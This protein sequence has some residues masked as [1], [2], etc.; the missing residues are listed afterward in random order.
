[1]KKYLSILTALIAV[2]FTSCSND[3]IPV[4][5]PTQIRVN[6][7]T[8]MSGFNYQLRPGD[9]DGVSNG[10]EVRIRL[11]I[12][13]ES[14]SLVE[15]HSQNVQNYL[16]TAT[17]EIYIPSDKHYSALALTDVVR[18]SSSFEYWE[19]SGEEKLSTMKVRYMSS[20]NSYGTQEILGIKYET[21]YPGDNR[22][23]VEAAGGLICTICSNIHAFSNLGGILI[24]ADR[25]NAYYEFNSWGESVANPDLEQNASFIFLSDIP[26]MPSTQEISYSY[27]FM[28]PQKNLRITYGFIDTD[29]EIL[30]A[31]AT[32]G[33][34]IEAC[35]EYIC[36]VELDPNNDG[37][38]DYAYGFGLAN[39]SSRST[40]GNNTEY[41]SIN[42]PAVDS[43]TYFIMNLIKLNSEK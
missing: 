7:A 15:K 31:S 13:D 8:V 38:G 34:N 33:I 21:L 32:D 42:T 24:F 18:K 4:Q 27:K 12:F 23:D 14:G 20:G 40:S 39:T 43:D 41:G 26:S 29:G 3:D 5:N 35:K 36:Y 25:G 28:M 11:Y 19:V 37:S 16:T 6:P 1:M 22:I 10:A 9:L 2:L 30:G 17:F